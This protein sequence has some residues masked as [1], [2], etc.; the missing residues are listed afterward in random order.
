[1]FSLAAS[2]QVIN[3]YCSDIVGNIVGVLTESNA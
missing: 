3:S 1:M 2:I